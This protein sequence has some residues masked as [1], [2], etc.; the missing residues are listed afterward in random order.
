MLNE[1]AQWAIILATLVLVLG[2]YRQLAIFLGA[3]N[4]SLDSISGPKIG[5]RLPQVAARRLQEV[6][7][8]SGNEPSQCTVLAFVTE[9]CAGCNRLL[10]SLSDKTRFPPLDRKEKYQIILVTPVTSDS[11]D[12]ALRQL[13]FP[14]IIDD[15]QVWDECNIQATP[16][17]VVLDGREIVMKKGVGH[18]VERAI[19]D[20]HASA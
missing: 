12:L 19:S 8:T 6:Q 18:D 20:A 4:S 17:L 10:A 15:G 5:R 7:V 11:F 13:G 3:D 1:A 2:I 14:V 9:G 16:F